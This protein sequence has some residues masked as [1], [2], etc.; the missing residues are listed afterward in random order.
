MSPKRCTFESLE[1]RQFLH[2]V[3][4]EPASWPP[5]EPEPFLDLTYGQ[6]IVASSTEQFEGVVSQFRS[7]L[8]ADE[9]QATIDWGDG[10]QSR[11]VVQKTEEGSYAVLDR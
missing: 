6:A 7:N 3:I 2:A 1:H 8:S 10:T 11:G 4:G 5:R 9:Y